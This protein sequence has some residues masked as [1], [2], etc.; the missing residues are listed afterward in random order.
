MGGYLNDGSYSRLKERISVLKGG[1]DKRMMASSNNE[2]YIMSGKFLRGTIVRTPVGEAPEPY[3]QQW[4]ETPLNFLVETPSDLAIA[5]IV[6]RQPVEKRGQKCYGVA[7]PIALQAL[8]DKRTDLAAD[9]VKFF[10]DQKSL[11]DL[12]VFQAREL[13]I[14]K[15]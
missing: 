7:T 10:L 13:K 3:R 9:A 2:W 14:Q 12:F 15:K 6:T 4:R 8:L 11:P 5:G 1:W